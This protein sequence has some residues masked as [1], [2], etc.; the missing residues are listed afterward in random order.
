MSVWSPNNLVLS[1]QLSC[2]I[3]VVP[4]PSV[5]QRDFFP[6]IP[7]TD[8]NSGRPTAGGEFG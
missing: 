7:Q 1:Q 8:G 4:G 6:G 3:N 5:A 2:L